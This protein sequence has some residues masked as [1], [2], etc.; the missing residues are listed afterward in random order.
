MRTAIQRMPREVSMLAVALGAKRHELEGRKLVRLGRMH[1]LLGAVGA[2]AADVTEPRALLDEACRIAV[3]EGAFGAAWAGLYDADG[4]R[5]RAVV[6]KGLGQFATTNPLVL[7]G[8]PTNGSLLARALATGEPS[9]CN[10]VSRAYLPS[11]ALRQEALKRGLRSLAICPLRMGDAVCAVLTLLARE[12]DAFDD[13]EVALLK[14]LSAD[15][16]V[17]LTAMAQPS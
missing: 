5:V 11:S 8:T 13:D 12:V 6:S 10:N 14:Q 7:T 16:S 3:Y 2:V 15:L 9:I 4:H 1:T 17:A